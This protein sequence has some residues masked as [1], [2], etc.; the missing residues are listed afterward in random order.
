MTA[1]SSSFAD[2][3]AAVMRDVQ[4]REPTLVREHPGFDSLRQAERVLS[5]A[6]SCL[7]E[8]VCKLASM[9]PETVEGAHQGHPDFRVGGRIYATFWKDEEPPSH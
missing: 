5:R 4:D 9:L 2:Q 6:M 3:H 1:P 8:D 7:P